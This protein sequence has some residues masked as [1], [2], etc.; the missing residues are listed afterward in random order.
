[1]DPISL[2]TV[3][4]KY[5]GPIIVKELFGL[6]TKAEEDH[7]P[8]AGAAKHEAVKK[9]LKEKNPELVDADIDMAISSSVKTL[10]D[11]GHLPANKV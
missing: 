6:I 9:S 7:G 4:V 2:L 11:A 1:M 3:A 5:L 8:K 10:S